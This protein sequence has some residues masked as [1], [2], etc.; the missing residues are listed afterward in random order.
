MLA[1][2]SVYNPNHSTSGKCALKSRSVK[3]PPDEMAGSMRV[4]ACPLEN[5]PFNKDPHKLCNPFSHSTFAKVAIECRGGKRS[6][7]WRIQ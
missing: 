7:Q 5:Y 6:W 2:Q 4:F 3:D 1:L